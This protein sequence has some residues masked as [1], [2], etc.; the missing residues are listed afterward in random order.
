MTC[1]VTKPHLT[2]SR[3]GSGRH[4]YADCLSPVVHAQLTQH[5]DINDAFGTAHRAH[6]SM[7]GVELPQ[8]AAGYL[9]K[10]ELEFFAKCVY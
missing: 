7:V 10:K 6:S 5:T 8:K 4:L 1:N 2:S 9:M 3:S